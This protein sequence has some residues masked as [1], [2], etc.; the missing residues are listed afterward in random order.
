[1]IPLDEA[2]AFVLNACTVLPSRTVSI[3]EALGC[4]AATAVVATEPVPPFRNSSMDGYA[5]RSVDT[6]TAAGP[7][8]PV[9]LE[10]VGTI[11]AGSVLGIGIGAR[12]A[13]RIMTG[14]QLPEG[15]DAV[16]MIEECRD[17]ADGTVAIVRP[18]AAGTFV[19][20]AGQDV[21]VGDTVLDAGAVVT[22]G[23]DRRAGQPG[24]DRSRGAAPAAPRRAH[25]W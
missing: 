24:R 13:A 8:D 10:V 11:M 23:H 4:V 18:V 6:T 20:T 16:C 25:H 12:Q 5:L 17:E 19:R 7:Q 15:A 14:G 21:R 3:D 2:R 9:R 1:M 22:P